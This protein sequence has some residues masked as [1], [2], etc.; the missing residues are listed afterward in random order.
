[1]S[2]DLQQTPQRKRR[3]YNVQ[4][5]NAINNAQVR[6]AKSSNLSFRREPSVF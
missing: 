1:M 6:D 4:E 2:T 5:P 3:L